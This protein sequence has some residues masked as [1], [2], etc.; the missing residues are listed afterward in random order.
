[1]SQTTT[2]Q[3]ILLIG[4]DGT[5]AS[6]LASSL[7][8]AGH[9]G[10]AAQGAREV[11]DL[12]REGQVQLALADLAG[13]FVEVLGGL[14]TVREV[15]RTKI[16][17]LGMGEAAACAAITD[18]LRGLGLRGLVPHTASPQELVF[19]VNRI[20]FADA[21]AASRVSPR[22][23]VNLP[24]SFDALD[25]PGQGRILNVSETGIFLSTEQLLPVNR[26][27]T[28][29]F[30]VATGAEPLPVTCRVVWSNAG[31]EGQRYFKG[32]GLQFLEMR[33]AVREALQRFLYEALAALE[34]SGV[35]PRP[36]SLDG[37]GTPHANGAY[38]P[39]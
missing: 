37:H 6:R 11:S 23:P 9:R 35:A 17:V 3:G 12:V 22:V 30:A 27:V 14:D 36:V 32:M 38:T 16:P 24:A 13:A 25:G 21:Q 4:F 33:P 1:M 7:A 39:R 19:R 31:G 18:A 10:R 34:Q 15:G 29:R 20:L 28:V 26:N 8:E 2:P 5:A